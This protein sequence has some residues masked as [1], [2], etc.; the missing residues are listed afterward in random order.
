MK[1]ADFQLDF[2]VNFELG[3]L[4]NAICSLLKLLHGRMAAVQQWAV[5]TLAAGQPQPSTT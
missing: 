3:T 2:C 1:K 5:V 4:A